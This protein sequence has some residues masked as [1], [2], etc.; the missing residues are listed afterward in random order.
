MTPCRLFTPDSLRR[1]TTVRETQ[2]FNP[3]YCFALTG[4]FGVTCPLPRVPDP[5]TAGSSTLG[6]PV[7]PLRG[8]SRSGNCV[9]IAVG[10]HFGLSISPITGSL[11]SEAMRFQQQLS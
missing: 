1:P 6:F 7:S 8:S 3:E 5:A 11:P 2:S 9:F 4:L 10:S